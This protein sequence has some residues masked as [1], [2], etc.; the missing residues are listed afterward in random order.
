MGLNE[1]DRDALIEILHR[2]RSWRDNIEEAAEK[3]V[4]LLLGGDAT[5]TPPDAGT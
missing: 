5:T 2:V 4:V 1:S 3:L